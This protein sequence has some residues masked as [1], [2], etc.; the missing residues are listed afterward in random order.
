MTNTRVLTRTE[1]AGF[2]SA[3]TAAFCAS[4]AATIYFCRSVSGGM[5]M[6]G[7]WTMSMM[8]MRMPGQTWV[9]SGAMFLLMWL[10]MMVAMMLPSAMPM[11]NSYRRWLAGE[12]AVGTST[13]IVAGGYFGV[14]MAIGLATYIASVSFAY[15]TMH[16]GALSHL[17]PVL[18]GAVL[19]LSGAIQFSRWKMT[20][21][22]RCRD[23]LTCAIGQ[24]SSGRESAWRYGLK[25]GASCAICCAGPMLALLVLGAMNLSVMALIA[26]VIT[27][28]KL[29]PNPEL[30]ARISGALAILVGSAMVL[31]LVS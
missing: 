16:W 13:L 14:W 31:R 23:P 11:L 27:L 22:K 26:V 10:A 18:T 9:R 12:S 20:A 29:A 3:C 24:I 7:G 6:P 4:T 30:M 28:E 5:E 8:W 1:S 21:L 17:V 19:V 2:L 15:A 25:Q